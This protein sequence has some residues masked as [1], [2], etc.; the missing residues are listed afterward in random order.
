MLSSDAAPYTLAL[1]C[2]SCNLSLQ[3]HFASPTNFVVGATF[4]QLGKS[5]NA[6]AVT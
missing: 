4:G 1:P 6:I 3:F 2:S 5:L